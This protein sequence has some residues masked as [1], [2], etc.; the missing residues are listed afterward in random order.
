MTDQQQSPDTTTQNIANAIQEISER[1]SVLVHEEI[2][3]AKAEMTEKATRLVKGAVI[4]MQPAFSSSSAWST[5][6]T[7]LRG[8]R[9]MSCSLTTSS[10]G[11]SSSWPRCSSSL[12]LWPATSAARAVKSGSPPTPVMAIDEANFIKETVQSKHPG[13]DHLRHAD[14][15]ARGDPRLDRVQPHGARAL[16][17]APARRGGPRHRLAQ[18]D[19]PAPEAGADRRGRGRVR[20]RG[21][22]APPPSVASCRRRR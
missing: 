17:H 7:A 18:A 12:A 8:W 14:P 5:C 1:V 6:C 4:G 13:A 15:Y 20:R 21:R 16:A 22:W 19:R 9:G 2:E 10:S 3:L 11:A